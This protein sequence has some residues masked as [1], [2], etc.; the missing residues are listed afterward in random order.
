MKCPLEKPTDCYSCPYPDCVNNDSA[1]T[2]E[3][4]KATKCGLMYERKE[5]WQE[6]KYV[7]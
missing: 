6:Q 5:G 4:T 3:E 1:P 2:K 7:S